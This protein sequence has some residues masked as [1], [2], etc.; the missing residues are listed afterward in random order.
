MPNDGRKESR[1][2]DV[3][4]N[5]LKNIVREIGGDGHS[6][7]TSIH[8]KDSLEIPASIYK[9]LEKTFKSDL[10]SAKSTLF[11]KGEP[12]AE[13]KGASTL[14]ILRDIASQLPVPV[15]KVSNALAYMGR[16]KIAMEL[17]ALIYDALEM[18]PESLE[19]MTKGSRI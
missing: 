13:I 12:V 11:V 19:A 2:L 15:E 1:W 16:G 4:V 18:K 7:L 5:Q 6:V 14:D 10:R 9:R 3:E 17:T 8:C